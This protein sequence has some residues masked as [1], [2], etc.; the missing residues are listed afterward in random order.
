[1]GERT[2]PA[3][4]SC[5]RV[6]LIGHR[7]AFDAATVTEIRAQAQSYFA[8]WST[9]YATIEA[10]TLLATGADTILT[11]VALAYGAHL[12]A[13]VPFA[14]YETDFTGDERER[15]QALLQRAHAVQGM[16]AV[17]R[18]NDAYFNASKWIIDQVDVILAVWD[19]ER[20]RDLGGTGDVVAYAHD[21]GLRV[22][23]IAQPR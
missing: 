15:Y 1:M 17:E 12:I 10:Y 13:V 21:R 18:S 19:G 4:A 14:D 2:Q 9:E 7:E 20:A 22:E 23:I 3:S 6:G 8:R 11:E 5:L 16:P